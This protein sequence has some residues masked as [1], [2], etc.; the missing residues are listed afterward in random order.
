MAREVIVRG[1]RFIVSDELKVAFTPKRW[2]ESK[3]RY[4]KLVAQKTSDNI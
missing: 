1:K 4:R 3:H 2:Y